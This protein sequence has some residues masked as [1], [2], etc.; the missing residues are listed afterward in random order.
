MG[1]SK[2]IEKS[3]SKVFVYLLAFVLIF[4]SGFYVTKG[5][6]N[7][8]TMVYVTKSGEKYH[9]KKCGR[10][11]FY[12]DTLSNA[13]SRGLEPCKKCFP[14]G[15]PS[16]SS[17]ETKNTDN[18]STAKKKVKINKTSIVLIVKQTAKLQLKNT[19][20]KITWSS[21]DSSIASVNNKGKVTAKKKGKTTITADA[22][23]NKKKCKVKVE[24]PKL[25]AKEVELTVGS[26]YQLEL[27]GCSHEVEWESD[28]YDIA[29]VD[30]NGTV[31]AMRQGT[32][33]I[34]ATV[35]GKEF[36]CKV[37]VTGEIQ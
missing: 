3:N 17:S 32:T 9:S 20:N 6:A 35:H 11:N 18:E 4:S 26:N 8:E 5:Q 36:V 14:N 23:T 7:A 15:A 33:N 2:V 1:I 30:D 22:G 25:N 34:Y 21:S 37:I 31:C 10:G 16:S 13:K 29:D 24:D 19:K 28:D 27:K 12:Q